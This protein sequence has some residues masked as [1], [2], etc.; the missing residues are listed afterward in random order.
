M[1]TVIDEGTSTREFFG[2]SSAGSFT[3]QIKR[4]IDT[5][6]HRP[7]K[8]PP[9]TEGPTLLGS[10]KIPPHTEFAASD[11]TYVLP[12]R[13]QADHLMELYWFYV[14][15]LYPFLDKTRW[16]RAYDAIFAGTRLDVD[17]Q[18]FVATLNVV[19]ALSTQ[20]VETL[21]PEARDKSSSDY[22]QRAQ[23]LQ[24]FH[25]IQSGSLELVQ[26]LLLASQFLQ[27]TDQPHL[28]WMVVGCAIRN[29]Q[30]LGMHL[31]ETS[32]DRADVEGRELIRR[33]WY[34]CVLMDR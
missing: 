34:G 8:N 3:A 17:E 6:L 1:T 29:A 20:L 12:P 19:L 7:N 27:S 32:A 11:V 24:P 33:V 18:L 4:A 30:S 9:R 5:R 28:T 22:I 16:R 25:M 14:D 13:R 2:S 26:Y 31:C 23:E 10:A 21:S 15:P